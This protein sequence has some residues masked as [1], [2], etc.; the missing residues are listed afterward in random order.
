VL[1]YLIGL[2]A[3]AALC[4]GWGLFQLWLSRHDAEAA[5]RINRC[6]NCSC[7]TRCE[8]EGERN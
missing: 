2:L 8:A 7:E 4:G 6:G 3:I 1:D 5:G